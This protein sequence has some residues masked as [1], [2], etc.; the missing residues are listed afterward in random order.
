MLYILTDQCMKFSLE[1]FNL[2]TGGNALGLQ[3]QPR[4]CLEGSTLLDMVC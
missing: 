2:V 1:G 3:M 4:N